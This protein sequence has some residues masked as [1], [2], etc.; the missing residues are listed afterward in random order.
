ME[1]HRRKTFT[2][3]VIYRVYI[4]LNEI[5]IGHLVFVIFRKSIHRKIQ[6]TKYEFNTI[7]S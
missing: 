1:T 3:H 2:F 4:H 5:Q 6:V 7:Y